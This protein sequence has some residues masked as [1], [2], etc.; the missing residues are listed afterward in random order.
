MEAN[1]IPGPLELSR[2][3]GLHFRTTK[4]MLDGGGFK[5]S[6]LDTLAATL[7]ANPLELVTAVDI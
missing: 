4:A 1:E 6:S 2:R 3:C 5:S 7:G